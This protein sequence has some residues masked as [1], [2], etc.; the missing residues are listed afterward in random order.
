MCF[1][2]TA[3]ECLQYPSGL[4]SGKHAF[5]F[6]EPS[7]T[8]VFLKVPFPA[9]LSCLNY[10]EKVRPLLKGNVEKKWLCECL[11]TRK[12]EERRDDAGG[13]E[14]EGEE[15]GKSSNLYEK[16][17]GLTS[18]KPSGTFRGPSGTAGF[19]S[20]QK[21]LTF[22]RKSCATFSWDALSFFVVRGLQRTSYIYILD[23][24]MAPYGAFFERLVTPEQPIRAPST[25][26]GAVSS[27]LSTGAVF[28]SAQTERA[29]SANEAKTLSP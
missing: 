11:K 9:R 17:S 19:W 3:K 24:H 28:S 15:G 2:I 8:A 10:E 5:S 13:R 21:H 12:G 18:G 23:L 25:C 27:D 6:R 1:I 4:T 20:I 7:G 22:W 14:E 26:E 16:P 29:K